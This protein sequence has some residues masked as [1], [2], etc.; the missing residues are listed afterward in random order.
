MF[1]TFHKL[2]W[3]ILCKNA[4]LNNTNSK[5]HS[6]PYCFLHRLKTSSSFC[7]VHWK[8]RGKYS[9]AFRISAMMPVWFDTSLSLKF[10]KYLSLVI[11][12]HAF[13]LCSCRT[14]HVCHYHSKVHISSWPRLSTPQK[15]WQAFIIYYAKIP[16]DSFI[17]FELT[18]SRPWCSHSLLKNQPFI[19]KKSLANWKHRRTSLWYN[20]YNAVTL[21]FVFSIP[22]LQT[23]DMVSIKH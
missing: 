22:I 10:F 19:Y 13:M 12:Y 11:Y 20:T 2:Q 4:F 1:A 16:P 7:S 17:Y 6:P 15:I 23:L 5:S 14:C 18:I 8:Q 3:S 9:A 21:T